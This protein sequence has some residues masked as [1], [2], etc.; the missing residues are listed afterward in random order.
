MALPIRFYY[1]V[2]TFKAI[3]PR[4]RHSL[5]VTLHVMRIFG[6]VV[7]TAS[8]G[9]GILAASHLMFL[10]EMYNLGTRMNLKLEY[11][12]RKVRRSSQLSVIAWC[13]ET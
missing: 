13:S 11:F 7:E 12:E 5:Y 3:R 1:V 9:I 2:T 4:R 8:S 6:S 10:Y